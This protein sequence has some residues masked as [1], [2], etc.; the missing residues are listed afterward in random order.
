VR[1]VKFEEKDTS[2]VMNY[3]YLYLIKF[4]DGRFYIGSRK[5][6]VPANEDKNYWGSPG[7]NNKLLW[8][9]QKEK[10]ILF[11]STNISL[12][13]LREKEYEMIRSGWKKFGKE[14]CI[15]K[16]AGGLDSI[17]EDG[18]ILGGKT[19]GKINGKRAK[20][21]RTGIFSLTKEQRSEIGKRNYE[22]G[23]GIFSFSEEEMME[24]RKKAGNRV[25]ELNVGIC[26]M[27]KEQRIKNGK[28]CHKLGV[29]IHGLSKEERIKNSQKS[30]TK[31]K[32]L[33]VGIH[34]L[35][36]EEKSRIA[37]IAGERT[38]EVTSKNYCLKSP[39]G[40]IIS[41]KNIGQFC[42]ENNLSHPHITSVL[43]GKRKHHRGWTHPDILLSCKIFYIRNP[44][45]KLFC[46]GNVLGF[47]KANGLVNS[48][49][50]NVLT[51]KAK[52]HKGW[53]KP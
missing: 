26:G 25:K 23:L 27:S 18:L 12:K 35:S 33:G 4:E 42:R 5:S 17:T 9:M 34:G 15:N 21:L 51:G 40:E 37:K 28:K 46:F 52:S 20:E 41:G 36:K 29:G 13:E 48:N 38:R 2:G 45:G 1:V 22:N 53:T 44:N 19:A 10:H 6:K 31:A 3:Y 16:N 14:K 8:E 50:H 39:S 32:E 47:C 24:I 49:I 43:N 11:E 7:K 30:G